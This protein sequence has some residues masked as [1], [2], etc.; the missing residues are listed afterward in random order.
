MN[1]TPMI[2]NMERD[3]TAVILASGAEWLVVETTTADTVDE[4]DEGWYIDTD[5]IAWATV[6]YGDRY[7]VGSMIPVDGSEGVSWMARLEPL[8]A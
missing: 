2:A 4:R 1:T 7:R 6:R 3:T 5:W 8:E